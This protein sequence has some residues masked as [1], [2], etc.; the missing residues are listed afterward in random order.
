MKTSQIEA[1]L[2]AGSVRP[3]SRVAVVGAGAVGGYFGGLLARAGTPTVMIGRESFVVAVRERGLRLDTR[4]FQETVAV[5]SA[6]TFDAARGADLVLFCVKSADTDDAA[7]ELAPHLSREAVVL[8]LQNGVENAGRIAELCG[9]PVVPAVVYLAASVPSPGVVKHVGRGDLVL[10]SPGPAVE[11][12]AEAFRRAGVG[13]IVSQRIEEPQWEKLV[14]N[15][16]LNALSALCQ[17]TYGD[18]GRDPVLWSVA[19][20]LVAETLLV[21]TSLGVTPSNMEDFSKASETVRKLTVQI[22]GAY[23]S[24][25][26][27]LRRGKRTEI[28]AL[29]GFIARKGKDLGV[30]T[31]VNHT[32]WALVRAAEA[33]GTAAVLQLPT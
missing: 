23:S 10:G 14:C 27:D 20:Q 29:N 15:V 9:R 18:L 30:P 31:P 21:A 25:A 17:R 26:Q 3:P 11:A 22:A 33:K 19:E 32:V 12:V 5:E 7:R 28:D 1:D 24:T 2:A 13:C 16:A 6:T 4:T 8:S